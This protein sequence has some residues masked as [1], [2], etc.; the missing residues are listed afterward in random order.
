MA[1]KRFAC[2]ATITAQDMACS[3]QILCARNPESTQKRTLPRERLPPRMR[4]SK[5]CVPTARS[6]C[7]SCRKTTARKIR[8]FCL[9]S[10]MSLIVR[11]YSPDLWVCPDQVAKGRPAPWMAFY[12][13]QKLD[14][15]PMSTFVKVGDT[16]NDVAEAHAAGM[17]AISITRSGNE[18]GLSQAEL[19]ALS[20]TEQS[21]RVAAARARLAACGPHYIIESVADLMP[22]VDDITA[23]LVRG[24]RP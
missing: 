10:A 16:P 17:W 14:V 19:G 18:V 8:S 20:E 15:Y 22:V 5:D 23:R 12:A 4:L 3:C 6:R 13:A 21:V 2:W 1:R 24:E 9:Y 11:G 7:T